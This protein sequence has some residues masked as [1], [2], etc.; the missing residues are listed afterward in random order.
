[1]QLSKKLKIILL[2]STFIYC[3]IIIS[4]DL[5]KTTYNLGIIKE[6][7]IIKNIKIKGDKVSI[8]SKEIIINYYLESEQQKNH[9]KTF[10][11]GDVLLVEGNIKEPL[12]NTIFNGFN[13]KKY[14]KSKKIYFILDADNITKINNNKN[15]INEI[16]N[17]ISNYINNHPNKEYLNTFVL[18]NKDY[19]E[20]D[21]V[22]SY[23]LNGISHLLAISG[24]HVSLLVFVLDK[25]IKKHKIIS[26]FLIFYAFLANFTPSIIRATTSYIFKNKI[27]NIDILILTAI[28]LL[29][30]NPFIIYDI[31]FLFS[32]TITLYLL[33]FKN[34]EKN[35]FKSLLKTSF[36]C[37]IVSIPILITNFFYI[38]IT[39]IFVNLI[40][41]PLISLVVFPLILITLLIPIDLTIL[42]NIMEN[43]SLFFNKFNLIYSIK[44]YNL[45]I[46]I[47]YYI[48]ITYSL[49]KNKYFILIIMLLIHIN[50]KNIIPGNYLT[51]IDVGQGD[52]FLLELNNK[53]ILIDTGGIITY[54]KEPWAYN[55]PYN[56]GLNKI[57]PYLR[58]RGI[59]KLDYLIITHGDSDHAKEALNIINNFKVEKVLLNSYELN[60]LEKQII[61]DINYELISE[62]TITLNN[63][64]LHFINQ[65]YSDENNDSLVLYM[66]INNKK[67]LFTGDIEKQTELN[68]INKYNITDI[69]YLKVAHHGSKTSTDINFIK[70]I[71]PKYSLISAGVN[72]RYNHPNEET[73]NTLKDTI[74][75]QTNIVGSVL[76]NLDNDKI[77]VIKK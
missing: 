5:K 57:I 15:I 25:I 65:A 32:F 18:G 14:L 72:N 56:M 28:V 35:Y 41:V 64:K 58:S 50:I 12:E 6:Q 16:K 23:Q 3:F 45:L 29:V 77:K 11:I 52:C 73:L 27:N 53:N 43:M 55:E 42:T 13:Y 47:I 24:M 39:S 61:K 19:L 63:H 7:F 49:Y 76:I 21:I 10:K 31:G 48:I 71:N 4:L 54:Q 75:Y 60:E 9:F 46:P 51:M 37:F 33:I 66:N 70:T 67:L 20:E 34:N 17:N 62:K 40:F 68:I 30:Y 36:T 44:S 22:T 8:T 69:D 74:I 26:L 38:N 59:N 1:M 2:F